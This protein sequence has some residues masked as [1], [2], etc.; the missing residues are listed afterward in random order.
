MH[1]RSLLL[2]VTP[3]P[4]LHVRLHPSSFRLHPCFFSRL[5]RKMQS[6]FLPHFFKRPRREG[7]LTLTT[8][9]AKLIRRVRPR[10]TPSKRRPSSRRRSPASPNVSRRGRPCA[11]VRTSTAQSATV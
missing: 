7:S 11:T 4:L 10:R 6:S 8:C 3:S 2:P 9:R 1:G 5:A